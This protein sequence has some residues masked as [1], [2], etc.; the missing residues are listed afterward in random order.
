MHLVGIVNP[1]ASSVTPRVRVALEQRL[2]EHH[3]VEF[4]ETHR[5]HHA[6]RLAHRAARDGAD[7]VVAIGGDGTLNE[8]ANGLLGTGTAL[9]PIPGGSTNVFA[10][11]IGYPN[12]PTGA[13]DQ[14]LRAL[15]TP[16]TT[17]RSMGVG[18]ADDRAFLFHV[19]IGFDAAVVERVEQ[20]G[21]LKRWAGHALFVESTI[22]TWAASSS[23]TFDLTRTDRP[24]A[25][26][27]DD[28]AAD[29]HIAIALNIDPYTFLGNR[30]LN[31]APE[32]TFD[33]P[34]SIVALHDLSARSLLQ[35]VRSS[36]TSA[37]GLPH[38]GSITHWSDVHGATVR[39]ASAVPYQVDGDLVGRIDELRLGHEA[40]ALRLVFPTS[41]T[42]TTR[43]RV[44]P[45][46]RP[47]RWRDGS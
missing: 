13:V 17:I 9:A 1:F 47:G 35:V 41:A 21:R 40:D 10:R 15:R 4:H 45:S 38:G 37:D 16:E 32:A 28:R 8:V 14:L 22:E 3:R 5:R 26:S 27:S 30:P 44:T 11:A 42:P 34:L 2:G 19:G 18:L 24:P 36:V 29:A 46:A 25:T 31:L 33:A 6:T 39:A 23:A 7:V 20:R 12:D 43:R